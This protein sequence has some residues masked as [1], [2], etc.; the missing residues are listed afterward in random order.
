MWPHLP[1]PKS[2]EGAYDNTCWF[3]AIYMY[4][5]WNGFYEGNYTFVYL[6]IFSNIAIIIS[7]ER[8]LQ[9]CPDFISV[10]LYFLWSFRIIDSNTFSIENW[11][12]L[13]PVLGGVRHVALFIISHEQTQ[14]NQVC[15]FHFF[16]LLWFLL[17]DQH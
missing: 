1:V 11:I 9:S 14:Y 6:L 13:K 8:V 7:G 12:M 4:R 3:Q 2:V 15:N 17:R 5:M 10:L 16:I